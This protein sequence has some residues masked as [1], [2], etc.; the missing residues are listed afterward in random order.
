MAQYVCI[1][2][3]FVT[4]CPIPTSSSG[5]E[6]WHRTIVHPQSIPMPGLGRLACQV[7]QW[8]PTLNATQ[9]HTCF[10]K[11][12]SSAYASSNKSRFPFALHLPHSLCHPR[13]E[14][15]FLHPTPCDAKTKPGIT[16]S[17]HGPAVTQTR[18][19]G[20]PALWGAKGRKQRR[21]KFRGKRNYSRS[22]DA[23]LSGLANS[24]ICLFEPP[25]RRDVY[26]LY[27][28]PGDYHLGN[29]RTAFPRGLRLNPGNVG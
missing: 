24:L 29:C 18:R 8:S 6:Q 27:N 25:R 3:V 14:V 9:V 1:H 13:R 11:V 28:L 7:A 20:F 19:Q 26:G 15:F 2:K 17:L 21:R 4:A 16:S 5:T 10:P 12:D 23:R 22:S